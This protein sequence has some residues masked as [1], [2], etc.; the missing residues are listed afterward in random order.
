MEMV[1]EASI[2]TVCDAAA[3]A[4]HRQG[5][6]RPWIGR[7]SGRQATIGMDGADARS[8][9]TFRYETGLGGVEMERAAV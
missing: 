8:R 2:A 4:E 1:E 5:P 7:W 6:L 3:M 9:P